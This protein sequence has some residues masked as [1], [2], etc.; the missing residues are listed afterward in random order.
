MQGELYWSCLAT[1]TF[2]VKN[3]WG[4]GIEDVFGYIPAMSTE[5][6]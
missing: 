5:T 3:S 2:Q 1:S 6:F 4:G